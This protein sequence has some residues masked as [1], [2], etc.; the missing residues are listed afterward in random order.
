MQRSALLTTGALAVQTWKCLPRES[1]DRAL[2]AIAEG[3]F[4][5][6]VVPFGDFKMD[7]TARLSTLEKMA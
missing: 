3:R 6:E 5:R 4:D 7:E 2:K 1:H